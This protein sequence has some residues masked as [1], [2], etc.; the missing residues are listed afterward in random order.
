MIQLEKH[1]N[2]RMV[3]LEPHCVE[4]FAFGRSAGLLVNVVE[5]PKGSSSARKGLMTID[6]TA[7]GKESF[8]SIRSL[9]RLMTYR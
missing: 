9:T 7:V 1:S 8:R 3:N 4:S 2:K 6:P 5:L